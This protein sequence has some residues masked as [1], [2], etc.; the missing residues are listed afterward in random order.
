MSSDTKVFVRL[1]LLLASVVIC[2][3]MIFPFVWGLILSFKDN[4]EI[5]NTPLGL[6]K[7]LDFSLYADT[8]QKSNIPNLFKNSTI[9]ASITT[10]GCIFIN[11]LSSF[12][13]ARLQH[14][15]AGFG[16]FFYFLF[17]MGNAV[18]LFIVIYPI[19]MIALNLQPIGMGVD[20]IFGLT[21][22]YI[23]GSL[24]FNTL[25]L[26]GGLKSVPLEMEEA[27]IM[28]GCSLP[29]MI[30]KIIA[31]LVAPVLTTLIIFNFIWAWNE[32]TL[33][34]I[35]LSSLKN[36]TIPMAAAFFKQQYGM[37]TAAVMRAVI[38]VLIPQ[39]IFYYIF[40][41]RIIQGMATTGLKS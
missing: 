2:S 8:F 14:R 40:Q 21:L 34:S 28:D 38:I 27:A 13:I 7:K 12:A 25:V 29:K 3:L 41:K 30:V 24:P 39:V 10:L 6:P 15:H 35:L 17:L 5:Y 31:P 23:A 19:Y 26:V 18:P 22:P 37:D 32:W 33:A 9:V 20:S 1:Y 4:T 16:N 36:F 11:F